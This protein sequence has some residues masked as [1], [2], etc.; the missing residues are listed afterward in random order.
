MNRAIASF[1]SVAFTLLLIVLL[2][3]DS[4]RPQEDAVETAPIENALPTEPEATPAD[5]MTVATE[6]LQMMLE[7]VSNAV[8]VSS[9]TPEQ[10]VAE[11]LESA[12]C[13]AP[14]NDYWKITWQGAI[15]GE[16]AVLEANLENLFANS[17]YE[18][19]SV[20]TDEYR[21]LGESGIDISL[22]WNEGAG[23]VD[24][25]FDSACFEDIEAN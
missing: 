7:V 21:I 20:G 22:V 16:K 6:E 24:T 2:A 1:L 4:S 9:W 8:P 12:S 11:L 17:P 14:E 18:L 19:S 23:V 15:A 25:E 13:E 10:P 5:S 3:G